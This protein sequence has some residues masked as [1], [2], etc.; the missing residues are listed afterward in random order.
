MAD[1]EKDKKATPAAKKAAPAKAASTA[2]APK[3]GA[4]P[5]AACLFE[6]QGPQA[7]VAKPLT[8]VWSARRHPR[9]GRAAGGDRE[10]A[11]VPRPNRARSRRLPPGTHR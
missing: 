5:A 6:G 1:K 10:A 9:R 3:A 4:K 8:R 11:P 2:K 7:R